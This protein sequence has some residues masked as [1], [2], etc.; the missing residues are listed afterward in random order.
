MKR[1]A[2]RVAFAIASLG[3]ELVGAHLLR[4][5]RERQ[6]DDPTLN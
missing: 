3:L 5:A 4:R 1:L 2:L 6:A